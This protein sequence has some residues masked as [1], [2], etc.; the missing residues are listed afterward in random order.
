MQIIVS[1]LSVDDAADA[2]KEAFEEM[3]M[4]ELVYTE[5]KSKWLDDKEKGNVEFFEELPETLA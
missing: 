4:L 2:D 5:L 3:S 1:C